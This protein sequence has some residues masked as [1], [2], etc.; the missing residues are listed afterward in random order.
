RILWDVNG[1]LSF[2]KP[3]VDQIRN[4]HNYLDDYEDELQIYSDTSKLIDFLANWSSRSTNVE[5]RIVDLM[6]AMA[7]E[8]FIGAG[9]VDLAER[10]VKDLQRMGYVFPKVTV[11]DEKT[12]QK[13]LD[14]CRK[15][16]QHLVDSRQRSQ[17]ALKQC[18]S[19]ADPAMARIQLTESLDP[20]TAFKDILLVVNFNW[21]HYD[22]IEQLLSIYKPYFPNIVMYGMDVPAGLEEMVKNIDN[23][24]GMIGYKSLVMAMEEYPN[25]SGYLYTNDDTVLNVFQLAEFDQDKVWKHVPVLTEDIRDRSKPPP[26]HWHWE[27][28]ESTNMWNDPTSLTKAQKQRIADFTKVQGPADIRAYCD[29]VYVP[30]RISLELTDVLTRFLK[31]N[32]FLELGVGLALVAIEP[33]ENWVDWTESYL[34]YDGERDLWRDYLKPGVGMLHPV[35]LLQ[36]VQAHDDIINWI[37]TVDITYK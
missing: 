26:F 32:V 14:T 18:K 29:A 37:Q 27:K 10:W 2:T 19:D 9:D 21:P 33:T 30:A 12:V 35:K 24:H 6:K 23:D 15:P 7:K 17:E 28:P 4:A 16:R 31:H 36:D 20:T 25:Y 5:T 34:W 11:Y 3:T 1:S 8:K 13:S 22:A